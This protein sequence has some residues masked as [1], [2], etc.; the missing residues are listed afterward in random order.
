LINK[1]KIFKSKINR[2]SVVLDVSKRVGALNSLAQSMTV[3]DMASKIANTR[4]EDIAERI[5]SKEEVTKYTCSSGIF[6]IDP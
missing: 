3:F 2:L 5:F 6:I 4:V 1:V